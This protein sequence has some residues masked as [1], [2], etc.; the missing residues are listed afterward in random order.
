L[1]NVLWR[2]L[3]LALVLFVVLSSGFAIFIHWT[4]SDFDPV[5]EIQR[6]KEENRRDDALDMARFYRE[7]Q[8]EDREKLKEVEEDL[9]YT[10]TEKIKSTIWN[11][12]IKGEVYDTY[13]GLGA[14]SADL[15]ILG[16]LRD[17]GI[18]S[19][20]YLVGR[21]DFDELIM[22]LA[23]AGVGLSGTGLVNGCNALVKNTIK[24]LEKIPCVANRGVLR[25]LLARKVTCEESDKIWHL[26]KKTNG[27]SR[28]P[29]PVYPASVK[30][31]ISTQP[32]ALSSITG[33][34]AMY[35]SMLLATMV[36]F[37][38]IRFPTG[39]KGFLFTLSNET[40]KPY[41]VSPR[42]ISSSTRSRSSISTISP[43]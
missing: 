16:D 35:L 32:Y 22:L 38:T 3:K 24:Y 43:L 37:F 12:A 40:L 41:W 23:A 20:K 18:Q 13:S 8:T 36:C 31:I 28:G 27:Q 29:Q 39:S 33:E 42:R 30:R 17:L 26:L 14:I 7:N 21:E 6:L 11:G 25:K 10:T 4:G 5:R 19:W 34:P 15:C 1:K 9:S 2:Y